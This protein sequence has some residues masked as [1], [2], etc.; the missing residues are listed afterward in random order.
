MAAEIFD[1]SIDAETRK[2]YNFRQILI[3]D[4]K[5][6][7][8]YVPIKGG[9]GYTM[10]DAI[11][12]DKNDE[13]VDKEMPFDGVGL[14]YVIVG[15]RIYEELIIFREK[16]KKYEHISWDLVSQKLLKEDG[17]TFDLLRFKVVC[18]K[19]GSMNLLNEDLV[20]TLHDDY[21]IEQH[22]LYKDSLE[23]YYYTDYYF[24]ITSFY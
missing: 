22:N 6:L 13:I 15:K 5:S 12:I 8:G 24:D 1:I 3:E 18:F 9:W 21:T 11:I 23:Y 2:H 7:N 4:F 17:R 19:E 10:D 16:G 14:E 20:K